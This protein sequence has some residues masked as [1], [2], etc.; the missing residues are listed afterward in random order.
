MKRH[1]K[2]TGGPYNGDNDIKKGLATNVDT[3]R[4]SSGINAAAVPYTLECGLIHE[5]KMDHVLAHVFL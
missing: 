2:V 4:K 3:T 1:V 5:Q